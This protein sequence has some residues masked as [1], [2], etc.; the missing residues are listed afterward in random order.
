MHVPRPPPPTPP[1]P[2][3]CSP[4]SQLSVAQPRIAVSGAAAP[5]VSVHGGEVSN[6]HGAPSSHWHRYPL[7]YLLFCL[8]YTNRLL[9]IINTSTRATGSLVPHGGV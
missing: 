6:G 8:L 9:R 1:S 7:R 4:K 5:R 3:P 2:F